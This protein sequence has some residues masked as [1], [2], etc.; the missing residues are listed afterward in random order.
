MNLTENIGKEL[1]SYLVPGTLAAKALKAGKAA[2]TLGKATKYGTAGIIADV[3]AKDEDE[4]YI[5]DTVNK[6]NSE[7]VV[8]SEKETSN[9]KINK[10]LN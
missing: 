6:I 5:K 4:Q 1:G 8:I 10:L 3:I 2:T 9:I 7:N